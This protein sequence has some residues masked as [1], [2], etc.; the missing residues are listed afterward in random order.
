MNEPI[1]S[2]TRKELKNSNHATLDACYD[3][4]KLARVRYIGDRPC[5]FRSLFIF[6]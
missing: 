2:I 4:G 3:C 5:V 1:A 6:L